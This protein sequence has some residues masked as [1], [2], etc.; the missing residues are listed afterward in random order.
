MPD[1][2]DYFSDLD[3]QLAQLDMPDLLADIAIQD[4]AGVAE[5]AHGS[6]ATQRGAQRR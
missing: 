4:A 1:L 3:L 5:R 2:R 6:W